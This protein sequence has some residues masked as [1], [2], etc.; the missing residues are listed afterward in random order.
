MRYILKPELHVLVYKPWDLASYL[1]LHPQ[2]TV[3]S[4]KLW[5]A[6]PFL[7]SECT[8]RDAKLCSPSASESHVVG[9]IPSFSSLFRC[10][11]L[12][13][14]ILA[15]YLKDYASINLGPIFFLKNVY[16]SFRYIVH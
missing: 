3:C 12:R 16:I 13:E 11:L 2:L 6:S 4:L 1:L 15:S 14:G 10:Y 9:S 5:P 8:I 7:G